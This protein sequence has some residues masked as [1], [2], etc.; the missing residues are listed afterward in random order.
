MD[1]VLSRERKSK[2]KKYAG[3]MAENAEAGRS[4]APEGGCRNPVV[5][6]PD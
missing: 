2:K 4:A 5:F 1:I 6:P 3:G